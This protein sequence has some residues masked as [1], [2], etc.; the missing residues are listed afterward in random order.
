[1]YPQKLSVILLFSLFTL[2]LTACSQPALQTLAAGPDQIIPAEPIEEYKPPVNS[3]RVNT[4]GFSAPQNLTSE[5]TTANG[6]SIGYPIVDTSQSNCYDNQNAITCPQPGEA[7]YGQDAQYAGLQPNYINNGDGTITD[8]NTGLMWQKT[9]DLNHKSTYDEAVAGAS[10]FNLAGYNDWR[11][12]TIKE[13]YSLID[14]NGSQ[15]TKT[16][17]INTAYFDFIFG[18]ASKG[19]RAI[20]A[21]Y[22]SSNKYIGT[23]FGGQTAVFGVNFAD[24]RIKGYGLRPDNSMTEFVRYVRGNPA[25]G[26]N[27]FVDNNDNTITDSATGLMWMKADSGI[28]MNWESALGYC[29]NLTLA[30]YNNWRLPNAKELHSIVDYT[31][32]P[33]AQNPAQQ[34]PAIDPIFNL[35]ATESWFWTGT[36]LLESPPHLGTGSQGVYFAFGQAYGVDRHLIVANEL[37]NVHGAGAQRGDPKSGDPAAW[38]SGFGPQNDEIR[39]YNYVRCVRDGGVVTAAVNNFNSSAQ[40]PSEN[41]VEATGQP[42]GAPSANQSGQPPDGRIPSENQAEVTGQPLGA[43]PTNQSGQP[44][45]GRTP[46][47]EAIDACN[48]TVQGNTCQITT[49]HGTLTGTCLSIVNQ[50]ACVP[51]GG[52]PPR[53][54]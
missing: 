41:Q 53:N 28:T 1:M 47:P 25:Y 8:L 26:L 19:E 44:P 35:T 40:S 17:Y 23:V 46:P 51:Q 33:D 5:Q 21:Q 34:G 7:F 13:L 10:A 32:A 3:T 36:T 27:N 30:S 2:I 11:L 52:P 48:G 42:L 12:P 45:D 37:I 49:P 54:P 38:S 14:Y 22:W 43:P 4:D 31:R 24:G 18:D 29:E 39:I 20:D 6:Y 16:P 15:M 9:P 50:L